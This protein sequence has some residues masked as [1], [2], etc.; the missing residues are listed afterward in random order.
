MKKKLLVLLASL[1]MV[2]MLALPAHATGWDG[3]PSTPPFSTDAHGSFWDTV[4]NGSGIGIDSNSAGMINYLSSSVTHNYLQLA[5]TG[6]ATTQQWAIPQ[7]FATGSEPLVSITHLCTGGNVG[8]LATSTT[9]VHMPSSALADTSNDGAITLY[10]GNKDILY[11][12]WA[13][14]DSTDATACGSEIYWNG[15][16]GLAGLGSD[17]VT[18]NDDSRNDGHRGVP[19]NV[20]IVDKAAVYGTSPA[21][22]HNVLKCAIPNA[23]STHVWPLYG[24]DGS[25][26]NSNA[27][28]EGAVLMIKPGVNVDSLLSGQPQ[29]VKEIGHALQDYGCVIGDTSGTNFVLKVENLV[30]EGKTNYWYSQGI[31]GTALSGIALNTTNWRVN[32]LGAPGYWPY[33]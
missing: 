13:W 23:A 33:P 25:N 8:S 27:I 28:P 26:T 20:Q 29:A 21:G 9:S 30:Q 15:S 6:D 16:N 10:D 11:T 12:N 5:G 31:D 17:A 4:W 19:P 1:P 7:F 2:L 24:S 18:G 3:T 22:I 32:T 14:V